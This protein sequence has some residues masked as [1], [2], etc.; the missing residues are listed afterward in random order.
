MSPNRRF[1]RRFKGVGRINV[2]SYTKSKRRFDRDNALLD[3]LYEGGQLDTLRA[4]KR[5]DVTMPEVRSAARTGK[6]SNNSLTVDLAL[7]RPLWDSVDGEGRAVKGAVS[8]TLDKMRLAA[9]S[10]ARYYTSFREIQ[11]L[12]GDTLAGNAHVS[13]LALVEWGE[14]WDGWTIEEKGVDDTIVTRPASAATKNRARAAVSAFLTKFL[15]DKYH[16]FRRDVVAKIPQLAEPKIPRETTIGQFWTLMEKVPDHA[17]E[18]F[19]TLAAT[20]IRVGEYLQCDKPDLYPETRAI[21]L[22]G[23]KT[24]EDVVYVGEEWWPYVERAIPCDVA[25]RPKEWRGVQYDARYKRLRAYLNAAS[26]ATGIKVTIHYL[27]H[28]FVQTGVDVAPE[29]DVQKAVRHRTRSMTQ[30]YAS[31]KVKRSV[32]EKV[33]RELASKRV[34]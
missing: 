33:G 18:D 10:R 19:V 20:G 9:A 12:A 2:S 31:R 25:P 8:A 23:G 29:A 34:G 15:G 4:L 3:Q 24:G 27:R 30:D 17:I 7:A 14:L 26:E 13:A 22:P 32:A 6:L 16:Q 1:D 21:H 28:L 11:D 5:G